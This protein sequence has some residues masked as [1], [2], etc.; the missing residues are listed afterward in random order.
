[1]K[2]YIA[3]VKNEN[4]K[5]NIM[6]SDVGDLK[7]FNGD[8]LDNEELENIAESNASVIVNWSSINEGNKLIKKIFS[9]RKNSNSINFLDLADP[10]SV[11]NRIPELITIIKKQ[12]IVD[13][14]SI[15]ENELRILPIR[16]A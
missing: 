16:N 9:N 2:D 11:T 12:K 14:L 5:V 15:N 13:I 8:E 3:V 4:N 6:F 7:K 1:M 10:K